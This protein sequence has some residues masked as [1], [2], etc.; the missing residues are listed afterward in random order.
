MW[1]ISITTTS[2]VNVSTRMKWAQKRDTYVYEMNN[3]RSK[4]RI[5]RSK[6]NII[7]WEL[8]IPYNRTSNNINHLLFV[9]ALLSFRCRTNHFWT[10]NVKSKL[11]FKINSNCSGHLYLRKC[12]HHRIDYNNFLL[13]SA[14][15]FVVVCSRFS[16]FFE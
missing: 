6:Y 3:E 14:T 1:P 13:Y 5:N 8:I 10:G 9:L 12:G 4:W 7:F 16:I 15:S 11:D 2:N